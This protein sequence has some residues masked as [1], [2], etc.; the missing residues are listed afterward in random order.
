M[1]QTNIWDYIKLD[2]FGIKIDYSKSMPDL[3]SF[4][5]E[6]KIPHDFTRKTQITTKS[7]LF[8]LDIEFFVSFEFEDERLIVI[9][10]SPCGVANNDDI[11][12]RYNDIQKTLEKELGKPLN[13][14]HLIIN[15][16][17]PNEQLISWKKHKL[18][19]RHFLFD[20]FGMEER[21][22]IRIKL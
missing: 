9:V 2:S 15:L 12:R 6:N 13:P 21:I 19:I 5:E 11:K 22:E 3:L 17:N 14:L 20:R 4:F 8:S 16:L 7:K 10:A 1:R 18:K